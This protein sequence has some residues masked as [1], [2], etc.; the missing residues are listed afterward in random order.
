[1]Q[2]EISFNPADYFSFLEK[3]KMNTTISESEL[4]ICKT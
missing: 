2:A 1:M 3:T 4:L